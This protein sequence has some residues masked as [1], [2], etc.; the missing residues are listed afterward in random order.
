LS[1]NGEGIYRTRAWKNPAEKNSLNKAEK[2]GNNENQ[3]AV[4]ATSTK[5][6]HKVFF[7]TNGNGLFA[8]TTE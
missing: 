8:L 6:I 4:K 5:H 7:T 2:P 3:T 1:I